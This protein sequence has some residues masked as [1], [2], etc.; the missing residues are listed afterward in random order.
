VLS[1][2]V[3]NSKNYQK[4]RNKLRLIYQRIKNIQ[5]EITNQFVLKLNKKYDFVVI[6]DLAVNKMMMNKRL[7]SIHRSLFGQFKEKMINKVNSNVILANQFY[8]STQRCSN[9]GYIKKGEDKIG[10][11]GNQKHKT[12]HSQYH[13]YSCSI[14]LDRDENAVD[15]LIDYGKN[16]L[17]I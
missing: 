16:Y 3:Y 4:V 14:H 5:L 7:K 9:C 12:N 6:E 15:N 2:K 13:C 10:L 11:A 17:K 8:P 1:K